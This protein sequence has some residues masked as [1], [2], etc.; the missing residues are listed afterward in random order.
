MTSL[1]TD[2]SS[3]MEFDV[4]SFL[5]QL[6]DTYTFMTNYQIFHSVP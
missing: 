6:T 5:D 2:Q 4:M 3:I 1:I